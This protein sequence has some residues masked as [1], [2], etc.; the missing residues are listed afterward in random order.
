MRLN[1]YDLLNPNPIRI[2][3]VGSFISPFLKDIRSIDEYTMYLNMLLLSVSDYW[4]IINFHA[5]SGDE[6]ADAS[7]AGLSEDH[8]NDADCHIFDLITRHGTDLQMSVLKSVEDALNFFMTDTVRFDEQYG[9]FLTYDGTEDEEHNPIPTGVIRKENYMD[10]CDII[11]RRNYISRESLYDPTKIRSKKA[12]QIYEK[13]MK[14]RQAKTKSAA[15]GHDSDL[16][17]GNIISKVAARHPSI[18]LL[19]IYE[20][21]IYQLYDQFYNLVNYSVFDIQG[22]A[23]AMNGSKAVPKFECTDWYKN[24]NSC[25]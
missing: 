6:A 19:N 7:G 9:V 10:V 8:L 17:L 1:Y 12:Q 22:M 25:S 3:Q 23:L 4:N 16:D 11:A 15:S 18:N 21:T 24:Y 2:P 20:L 13:M 14:G 5:G